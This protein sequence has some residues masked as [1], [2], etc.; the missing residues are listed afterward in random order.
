LQ[1]LEGKIKEKDHIKVE[2]NEEQK[3][4]IFMNTD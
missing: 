3:E 4:I 1:M 2:F